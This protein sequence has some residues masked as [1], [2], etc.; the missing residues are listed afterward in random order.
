MAL[1]KKCTAAAIYALHRTLKIVVLKRRKT[2]SNT[3]P[4]SASFGGMTD[5]LLGFGWIFQATRI[6]LLATKEVADAATPNRILLRDFRPP[7][8]THKFFSRP[9]QA[10]ACFRGTLAQ[11]S[12]SG[13]GC[14][15][16]H[17]WETTSPK[18]SATRPEPWARQVAS[19]HDQ[20]Q[21]PFMPRF[22]EQ[23]PGR[24]ARAYQS[25]T[26]R[27]CACSRD[28]GASQTSRSPAVSPTRPD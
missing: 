12:F 19:H 10:T 26:V 2:R 8:A 3:K 24:P 15:A 13:L 6:I 27:L 21:R 7:C 23:A 22:I 9:C 11:A 28:S 1:G 14:L 16:S 5:R 4:G 20:Q 18:S 17:S 25:L